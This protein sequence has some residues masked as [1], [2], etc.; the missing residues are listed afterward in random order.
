[1][2]FSLLLAFPCVADEGGKTDAAKSV[3]QAIEAFD[4]EMEAWTEKAMKAKGENRRKMMEARPDAGA[5]AK[6]VVE[7]I[8]GSPKDAA[9]PAAAAWVL[10]Q[11]PIEIDRGAVYDVLLEHHL[12]SEDLAGAC[13][14][15]MYDRGDDASELLKA[16]YQ[17]AKSPAA[18][19]AAAYALAFQVR[20]TGGS[21]ENRAEYLRAV[22]E[23]AGEFEF[24]GRSI[25]ATAEGEL[26]A[27]E[28][29]AIGKEAPEI[30]GEDTAG[31]KFKLSAYRGK[32]VV[33]D[34]WG[35]W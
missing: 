10:M 13:M 33:I 26:F 18:K 28:N 27:A 22:V 21:D 8:K 35:D 32:V 24:R 6:Q 1:M 14:G 17:K 3:E 11:R 4:K 2:L 16:A 15:T 7:F 12:E 34:F 19:G 20:M 25:K 9:V 5:V 29:L 23:H 31:E 30:E